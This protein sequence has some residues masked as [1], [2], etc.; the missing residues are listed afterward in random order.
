[1]EEKTIE[2]GVKTGAGVLSLAAAC[3]GDTQLLFM[4]T[5]ALLVIDNIVALYRF[6]REGKKGWFDRKKL[7]K[8]LDKFISYGI[9][10]I[11]A[12]LIEKII[13]ADF[14]LCKF[15]AGYIAIYEGISIFSHL[16]HITGL[17]LF[18]D[19]VDWLKNKVDWKKYFNKGD[20]NNV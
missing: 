11:V 14:G 8:T 12:W 15:V 19:V 4:L 20:N 16:G 18:A 2:I 10:I 6:A 1:M 9:A 13:G 3:W 17:T 5:F 7:R